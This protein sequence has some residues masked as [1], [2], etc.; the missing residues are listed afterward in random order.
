MLAARCATAQVMLRRQLRAARLTQLHL[1]LEQQLRERS[2]QLRAGE[3]HLRQ[4]VN[5]MPALVA[6]VDAQ[7]RYVYVNQLYKERFA[8][9]RPDI[10]GSTVQDVLG[11]ERY[12]LASPMINLVLQ[13]QAQSYDVQPFPG[14]WHMISYQPTYD[15]LGGVTGYYVMGTDITHIKI[16]EAE[17]DRVANYDAL[18]GL[19][20]RRLLFDRLRQALLRA[21]R[22]EKF[23]AVCFLDLD[24]FKA[25]N[26]L[27]GHAAGDGVLVGM[28]HNLS[29]TLR[30]DDTLARLGGDEFVA[31]LLELE[32]VEECMLILERMLDAA[33]QPIRAGGQ[34]IQTS[35]SIGVSLYPLDNADPD[36]LLRHADMAMYRAKHSGKNCY[37]LFDPQSDYG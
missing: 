21:D 10:V 1:L 31:L 32:S 24:G 33:R 13:G 20:N 5:S 19:P 23:C 16:H 34:V 27:L 17:L 6:Y 28:A 2:A 26:D 15:D 11:P 36:L 30:A 14:V 37:H 8:P 7:Q 29:E 35:A 25:I 3:V 12:A 18:T 22:S 4:I 9:Y